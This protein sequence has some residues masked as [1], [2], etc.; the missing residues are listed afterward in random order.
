MKRHMENVRAS[1]TDLGGLA[2]KTEAAEK[3]ILKASLKRLNVV[4][5]ELERARVGIEAAPEKDQDRYLALVAERGQL[6]LVISKA[7]KVLGI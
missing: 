2:A 6:E 4:Q 3:N 7:R 5:A 1:L